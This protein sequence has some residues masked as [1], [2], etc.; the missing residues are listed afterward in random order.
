MKAAIFDL[1]GTLANTEEIHKKAW[2]I[3][4]NKLGYNINVD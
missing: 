3:A 2:E 4:L 1:D